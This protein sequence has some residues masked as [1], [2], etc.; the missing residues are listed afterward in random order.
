[1]AS[2]AA[3][4]AV[5]RPVTSLT[6]I[7][8]TYE[9]P[10]AL[11]VVLRALSEQRGDSFDV[12]VAEDAHGA[13][14]QVVVER[15]RG[16]FGERLMHVR[17]DDR[18]DRRTRILNLAALSA[19]GDFLLFVDGDSVPRRR[20]VEAVRRAA[21][22]GWFLS[23]KR[24]HLSREFSR[25]VIDDR[26]PVWRWSAARWLVSAPREFR[27][28]GREANTIGLLFPARDRRRPWRPRQPEFRPPYDA[29]GFMFGVARADFERVNGFDLRF[30]G[31]A[32]EDVDLAVRLRRSGLRCGWAG[33]RSTLLHLWHPPRKGQ[34]RSNTPLLRETEASDRIEAVE[35]LREL[36]AAASAPSP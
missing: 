28:S 22:P 35:G 9:W 19:R 25:R 12:V 14:T 31:Y 15:W 6:V 10:S 34:M 17:Q 4:T 24:F 29:Y 21:L 27:S 23:S 16:A 33:P 18:G 7:V 13:E 26:L 3:S 20:L 36:R 30:T 32:A 1:M 11:D 2:V 8:N 5:A